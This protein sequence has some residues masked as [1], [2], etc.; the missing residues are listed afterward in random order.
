VNSSRRCLLSIVILVAAAGCTPSVPLARGEQPALSRANQLIT[1]SALEQTNYT[2][3][4]DPSYARIAYPGGDVPRETGVCSDVIIRA[5]RTAGVDLQKE[6]HEDMRVAF[7][8]YPRRWGLTRPDANIDHRR[9]LNLMVF[10]ERK[11]KALPVS[12]SPEDYRP[13]DVVAWDLGGGVPHIGLVSTVASER[14]GY[15]KVVHN[16]GA[17]TRLEDVLFSWTVIGHYRCFD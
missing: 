4:Y 16:I 6:V 12:R 15:H 9:V 2:T 13:G 17:G 14:G 7:K 8:A 5:F 10:F 3:G 1:D 11:G